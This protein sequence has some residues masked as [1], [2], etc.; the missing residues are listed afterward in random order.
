MRSS[1]D[2]L[3][4]WHDTMVNAGEHNSSVPIKILIFLFIET[5]WFVGLV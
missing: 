4:L 1:T 3:L 2:S 5:L